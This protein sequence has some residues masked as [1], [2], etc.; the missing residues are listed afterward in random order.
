MTA[1]V[2]HTDAGV[3]LW[4]AGA[5]GKIG[6]TNQRCPSV[7]VTRLGHLTD[8]PNLPERPLLL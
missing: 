3:G 7:L 5:R 4:C 8:D 1:I 2:A 6:G